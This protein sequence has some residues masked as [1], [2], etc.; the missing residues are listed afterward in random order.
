MR[1]HPHDSVCM[2]LEDGALTLSAIDVPAAASEDRLSH[3]LIDSSPKF[4]FGRSVKY[5]THHACRRGLVSSILQYSSVTQ[6]APLRFDASGEPSAATLA[7]A[8]VLSCQGH[9]D[10]DRLT[11]PLYRAME[12]LDAP[13]AFEQLVEQLVTSSTEEQKYRALV[14]LRTAAATA[15]NRLQASASAAGSGVSS[16]S[17]DG[18]AQEYCDTRREL[19]ERVANGGAAS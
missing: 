19:L 1:P 12:T 6:G 10:L 4:P 3:L 14:A 8:L 11:E 17:F 16:A 18:V 9:E 13:D 2:R 15:V 7:L 5:L